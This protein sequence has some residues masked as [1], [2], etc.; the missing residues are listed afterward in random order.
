MGSLTQTRHAMRKC[1]CLQESV[2]NTSSIL[3]PTAPPFMNVSHRGF[4]TLGMITP[5]RGHRLKRR[6]VIL[7][8]QLVEQCLAW[9]LRPVI[10]HWCFRPRVIVVTPKKPG[11]L[12]AFI[13]LQGYTDNET[14]PG[15]RT[16][17]MRLTDRY[18]GYFKGRNHYPDQ[19]SRVCYCRAPSGDDTTYL[20]QRTDPY[21]YL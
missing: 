19:T 14:N 16:I 20:E 13:H 17:E 5:V 3:L 8:L 18:Q 7:K 12:Y 6:R 9:E 10:I 4:R 15:F 2:P 11:A 21:T 1:E